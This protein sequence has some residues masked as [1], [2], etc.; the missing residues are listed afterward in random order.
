MIHGIPKTISQKNKPFYF[1]PNQFFLI[2]SIC[3]SASLVTKSALLYTIH[4][5]FM[6]TLFLTLWFRKTL[7][8]IIPCPSCFETIYY[9]KPLFSKKTLIQGHPCS[10][11]K[12]VPTIMASITRGICCYFFFLNLFY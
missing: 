8:S 11:M 7:G 3:V 5:F 10:G 4:L 2:S 12:R 9:S 1:F 6:E